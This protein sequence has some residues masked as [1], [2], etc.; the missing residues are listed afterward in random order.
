ML[1]CAPAADPT[2]NRDVVFS[3][4]G[5][6][7]HA[8]DAHLRERRV[9][10]ETQR[11]VRTG[12]V[13]GGRDRAGRSP[14]GLWPQRGQVRSRDVVVERRRRIIE[15]RNRA[16]AMARERRPR[17]FEAGESADAFGKTSFDIRLVYLCAVDR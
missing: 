14:A 7:A 1:A 16:G 9:P 12:E 6:R 5:Q 13:T 11:A 8:G 17:H 10:G 4:R 2:W 15:E 3:G